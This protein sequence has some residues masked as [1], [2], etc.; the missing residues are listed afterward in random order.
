MDY[1]KYYKYENNIYHL[2]FLNKKGLRLNEIKEICSVYGKTVCIFET[3]DTYGM[4]F[5]TF[6][7]EEE[8]INCIKGLKGHSFIELLPERKFR[9]T[10][11]KNKKDTDFTSNCNE[12]AINGERNSFMSENFV[13][14][15]KN[16]SSGEREWEKY[17]K[18]DKDGNYCLHFYENNNL[19]KK[20]IENI[21]SRYGNVMS[22][23]FGHKNGIDTKIRFVA[24]KTVNEVINC[25]KGLQNNKKIKILPQK[26]INETKTGLNKYNKKQTRK[27]LNSEQA[28]EQQEM[29][30]ENTDARNKIPSLLSIK[31]PPLILDDNVSVHPEIEHGEI[32]TKKSLQTQ[33]VN[34]LSAGRQNIP[35]QEVIVANIH[36][37]Y[38]TPYILHLLEKYGPVAATFVKTTS[39]EIRY[40]IVYLKSVQDAVATEEELD[41]FCLSGKNLIV[42]RHSRLTREIMNT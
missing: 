27:H 14:D 38:G 4:R 11:E 9:N 42:L 32:N 30:E 6:K 40:C 31:I 37:N 23:V 28:E 21:F 8:T 35:L 18:I 20:E 22:V 24:Y 29:I 25:L 26:H 3:A 17:T 34:D 33:S 13:Q 7:T 5:I 19:N 15:L 36:E 2:H 10:N 12:N 41:N 1:K 39:K 16:D